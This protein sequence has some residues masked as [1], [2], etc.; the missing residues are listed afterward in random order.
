MTAA[1]R[2]MRPLRA[3]VEGRPTEQSEHRFA[4]CEEIGSGVFG[5]VGPSAAVAMVVSNPCNAPPASACPMSPLAVP[6]NSS[7]SASA[8][9]LGTH[10]FSLPAVTQQSRWNSIGSPKDRLNCS[11]SGEMGAFCEASW[12]SWADER[13]C[14]GDLPVAGLGRHGLGSGLAIKLTG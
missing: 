2:E 14:T 12:A 5:A 8:S 9:S 6:S 13:I 4:T 11:Q 10:V 3:V 7:E 1:K